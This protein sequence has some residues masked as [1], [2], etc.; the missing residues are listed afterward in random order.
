MLHWRNISFMTL[1]SKEENR[2]NHFF[3]YRNVSHPPIVRL[4]SNNLI[5]QI[6]RSE[7]W[8]FTSKVMTMRRFNLRVHMLLFS[9]A[10]PN[11]PF[12]NCSSLKSE[13]SIWDEIQLIISGRRIEWWHQ[14]SLSSSCSTT[15]TDTKLFMF[16]T[17]NRSESF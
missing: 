16:H 3:I 10:A 15:V 11:M 4:S 5:V 7:L 14:S 9:V 6:L 2:P 1:I 12:L 8:E 13:T 17:Y